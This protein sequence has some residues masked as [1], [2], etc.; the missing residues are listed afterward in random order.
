VI[1]RLTHRRP[2]RLTLASVVLL[3]L[4]AAGMHGAAQSEARSADALLDGSALNDVWIHI[5]ARDWRDLHAH[6]LEDTYYPADFEWQGVN[7]RNS[8]IRARGDTTRNGQKPSVRVAFNRYVGGQELLGLDAVV[9]N[10]VWLDPSMIRDRLSMLVFRAAGVPAPRQA[11][12][13]LFVGANREYAGVYAVSEEID[14]KFAAAMLHDRDG[15]LF[16]FHRQNGDPWGFEDPG[17]DLRWYVPRFDPRTHQTASVP[18]LYMPVRDLV[19]AVNRARPSELERDLAEYLDLKTFI[20]MLAVQNF[21]AQTDGLVSGVGMNNFYLYRYAGTRLSV[22][23]PWDQDNSFSQIMMPPW[24]QLEANVLTLKIWSEPK[25][26]AMYLGAL[27]DIADLTASGWL[28]QEARREYDQ[29][30]EA[31]HADPFAPYPQDRFEQDQALVQQF[32]RERAAI[33]RQYVSSVA[34]ELLAARRR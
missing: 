19:E 12:V 1:A 17:P 34:P 25:Y 8:G 33:V 9:L 22:I 30:R 21:V 3:S 23:I 27:L 18:T 32:A 28:E 29:I 14:E 11:H 15:Y 24:Q 26:R 4:V 7:V 10:S 31:A 20:T 2:G 13:R 5:N 16:E 6:Y